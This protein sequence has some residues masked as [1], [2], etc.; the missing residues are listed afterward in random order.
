M[1]EGARTKD[2]CTLPWR[3]PGQAKVSLISRSATGVLNSLR[4]LLVNFLSTCKHVRVHI[5][6]V[7]MQASCAKL[8]IE[9]SAQL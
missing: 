8:R 2:V 9:Y 4:G 5:L 3:G 1:Q 6:Q 7:R